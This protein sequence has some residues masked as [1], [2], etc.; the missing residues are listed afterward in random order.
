MMNRP[1]TRGSE[2]A[3]DPPSVGKRSAFAGLSSGFEQQRLYV[4]TFIRDGRTKNDK[5]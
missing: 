5:Y 4:C 3:Y 2:W 1:V